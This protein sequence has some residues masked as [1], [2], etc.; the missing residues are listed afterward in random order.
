MLRQRPGEIVTSAGAIGIRR[1]HISAMPSGGK[2]SSRF[3]RS[4][5]TINMTVC[6]VS[7]NRRSARPVLRL[8]GCAAG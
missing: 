2:N 6:I 8:P 3:T 4:T 7:Q 5:P 1:F